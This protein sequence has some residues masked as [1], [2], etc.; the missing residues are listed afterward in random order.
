MVLK[1][2]IQNTIHIKIKHCIKT[3]ASVKLL[4]KLPT[5]KVLQ[6]RKNV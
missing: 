6:K 3:A 4:I 1:I 2:H 5:D